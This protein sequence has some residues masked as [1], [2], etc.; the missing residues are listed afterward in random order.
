MTEPLNSS[1]LGAMGSL[2]RKLDELLRTEERAQGLIGDLRII[3]TKMEELL[4]VDSPPHTVKYWMNEARELSYDMEICVDLFVHSSQPEALPDK[5][6]WIFTWH[7]EILGFLARVKEVN[8]RC[9]R[10]NLV[11][12]S[13]RTKIIASHQLQTLY[14][15]PD[16][17]G[18]EEPTNKLLEWLMLKD[19]GEDEDKLNVVSVLGDEGV[20]KSTLVKRLWRVSEDNKFQFNCRAF[21]QAAKKPDTRMIL[22][23]ILSQVHPQKPPEC[24]S[25]VPNLIRYLRGHL[26]DKRYF[27]VIDDLWDISVWNIVRQAFPQRKCRIITATTIENVARACCSYDSNN[28]VNVYRLRDS[29]AKKLF[30]DRAFGSKKICPSQFND[31]TDKVT[32]KCGGLPLAIICTARLVAN[33]PETE[34]EQLLDYVNN[35]LPSNLRTKSS[36]TEILTQVLNLCYSRLPCSLRTCLLYL[37]MYP[38]NYL[39]L[40]E[41]LVKQWMAEDFICALDG[42]DIADVAGGY[43]DELVSLGMIQRMDMINSNKKGLLSYTVHPVVFDFVRC[44]STEDNFVTTIDYSQSTAVVLTEKVRRLSL[45]FGSATY[46]TTPACVEVSQVRS[47]SFMGLLGC[48]PS[49]AEFMLVRVVILHIHSDDGDTKFSLEEICKLLQL[50]YLQVQCNVTVVLPHQMRSLKHLETV[51]INAGVEYVPPDMFHASRLLHVRLVGTMTSQTRTFPS[52]DDSG[53]IVPSPPVFLQSFE[54]LPPI[55]IFS[56]IPLWFRELHKLRVLEIVV[57]KL[58]NTIDALE[59]LPVLK[60]LSLYVRTPT[61]VS[62]IFIKDVFP[63]LE[64][65]KFVCGVLSLVF[66]EEALPQLRKLKLVFNAHE[67]EQYRNMMLVGIRHLSSLEEVVG[68][69]GLAPD[70]V[71]SD[72]VAAA[73]A[74]KGAIRKHPRHRSFEQVKMVDPVDED[75]DDPWMKLTGSCSQRREESSNEREVPRWKLAFQSPPQH[76]IFAGSNIKDR[77]GR[78]LEVILVDTD[79]GSPL[80][81]LRPGRLSKLRRRPLSKL[82]PGPLSKLRIEFVPLEG[83]YIGLFGDYCTADEFQRAVVRERQGKLLTGQ[84]RII[85]RDG[86]ATVGELQFSDKSSWS[87]CRRFRIGARVVPGSYDGGRIAEA[88]TENFMVIDDEHETYGRKYYAPVLGDS[89]W[90]LDKIGKDSAFHSKLKRNNIETVQEFLRML[91]VKPDQLR[92][93]LG[94]GMTDDMWEATT[95]HARTC[96]PGNKVYAYSSAGGTIYTNSIFNLVKVEI[97]GIECPLHQL[98]SDQT[99]L[100]RQLSLEAYEHPG[101]LMEL[102]K[103]SSPSLCPLQEIH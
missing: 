40:K 8:E 78:P 49:I 51:E 70:A 47:L 72:R 21:V 43:F 45:H 16:P 84:V 94:D 3:R 102:Q 30:I 89:V 50:R 91:M 38:E 53:S 36:S 48:M 19:H 14:E 46:A 52:V 35:S 99:M 73:S 25:K 26:Q 23:S 97:G 15:E 56:R 80:S 82:R 74:F 63:S 71:E 39:F 65:F 41:D 100:V 4:K 5:L 55:C 9:E 18:M 22:R 17:F 60:H 54:L 24:S 59:K 32:G 58:R 44:K 12:N 75:D 20:G 96:D 101:K 37:S 27:I 67:G 79:T 68:S 31:V 92:A 2:L 10:Y 95:K 61:E 69:I 86:R 1:S 85:M 42:N 29:E 62:I 90:R 64:Y 76:I 7:K 34:Q 81:K 93:I 33:Q 98:N 103:R 77:D 57:R 6:A 83:D 66:L 28:I 13:S 87:H 11:P 88:I